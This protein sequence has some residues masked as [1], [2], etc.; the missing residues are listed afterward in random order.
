MARRRTT[1]SLVTGLVTV[2]LSAGTAL[3]LLPGAAAADEF[4]QHVR[5]C[6]QHHGFDGSHNPGMHQGAAGWDHAGC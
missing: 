2:V 4:G 3:A 1:P 5:H 6:A